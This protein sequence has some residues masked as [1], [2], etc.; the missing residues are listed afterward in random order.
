MLVFSLWPSD[1]GSHPR[2]L[3]A[4]AGPGSLGTGGFGAEI[5]RTASHRS[6]HQPH[7]TLTLHRGWEEV[8]RSLG[9][10]RPVSASV[11]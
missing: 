11:M 7:R 1:P 9:D 4:P 6:H 3:V 8:W 2:V 5:H 10:S